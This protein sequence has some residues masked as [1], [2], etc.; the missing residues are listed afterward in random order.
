MTDDGPAG[1]T[2]EMNGHEVAGEAPTQEDLEWPVG[3]IIMLVLV[4]LYLGWRLFQL[5]G[6]VFDLIG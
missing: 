6:G 1:P 2:E 3:F 5:L 4:A